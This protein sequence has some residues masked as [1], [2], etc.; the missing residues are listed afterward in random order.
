MN[1]NDFTQRQLKLLPPWFG[2][3]SP[4][5]Q[6]I[7][8]GPAS[9]DSFVYNLFKWL[10]L[11]M[12]LQTMSGDTLDL[13]A[14]DFFGERLER[15]L[16]ELDNNY[17]KRIKTFL[18]MRGAT[19][20]AMIEM[21]TNLT[22]HVPIIFVPGQDSAFCNYSFCNYMFLGSS[23]VPYEAWIIAFRPTLPD[24]EGLCYMNED[25]YCNYCFAMGLA[26]S[27]ITDQDIINAIEMTKSEGTVMH[28]TILDYA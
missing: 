28:V 7:L 2:N 14:M 22:G 17:R 3:I 19:R 25:A 13:F 24:E 27:S 9:I 26:Q 11:Q 21:L 1:T 8:Q 16:G 12:R 5:L 10:K 15:H 23:S 6:E 18:L 20:P 4:V